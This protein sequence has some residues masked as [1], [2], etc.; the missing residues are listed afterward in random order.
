MAI[1]FFRSGGQNMKKEIF[2]IMALLICILVSVP[3]MVAGRS[4]G[5][6]VSQTGNGWYVFQN[7]EIGDYV[8]F[9]S[10]EQDNNLDNGQEPIEW[11]VLDIQEGKA[12]LLS[13][14][15]LDCQPY[16]EE[17]IDVT[18]ETCSLRAWLNSTFLNTA[19]TED[20]ISIIPTVTVSADENPVYDTDPGN[21]TKDQ[22]FLL[23]IREAKQYLSTTESRICVPTAYAISRGVI[24]SN[25]NKVNS[26]STCWW[27]LRSPGYYSYR[28]A[29]VLKGGIINTLGYF[30]VV[31]IGTVRPALWVNL[32]S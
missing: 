2:I 27:W 32:Q 16:N 28:A 31:G 14:Y 5:E 30:V 25:S 8:T 26:E 29:R 21:D 4:E 20:E 17:H 7:A 23:S 3:V 1:W 13:R 11:E 10:Y 6:N 19:F 18:W 9:G 24:Q 22:V 12:L 15:A